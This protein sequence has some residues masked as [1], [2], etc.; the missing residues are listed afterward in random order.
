[1]E[2]VRSEQRARMAVTDKSTAINVKYR[3]TTSKAS[4]GHG[5]KCPVLS[6]RKLCPTGY[7]RSESCF[8]RLDNVIEPYAPKASAQLRRAKHRHAQWQ[9]RER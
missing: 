2:R 9:R 5:S 4:R 6:S 7:D 8:G 1:M 3:I